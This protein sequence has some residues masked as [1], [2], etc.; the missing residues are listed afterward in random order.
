MFPNWVL[1]PQTCEYVM[2]Q[3]K[4]RIKVV[5]EIQIANQLAL[6]LGDHPGL[7]G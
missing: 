5:G 2:L 6:G 3:G 4:G 1:I 7:S